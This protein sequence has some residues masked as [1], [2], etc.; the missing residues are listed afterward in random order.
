MRV[1]GPD[2]YSAALGVYRTGTPPGA[3]EWLTTPV[4]QLDR[5]PAS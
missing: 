2:G 4:A 5:A 3:P 1:C